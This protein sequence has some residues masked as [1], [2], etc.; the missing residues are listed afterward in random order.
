MSQVDGYLFSV[1]PCQFLKLVGH[2]HVLVACKLPAGI[3]NQGPS[4]S[5][6]GMDLA[7]QGVWKT[8]VQFM[9]K[10]KFAWSSWDF[11][12]PLCATQEVDKSFPILN[13]ALQ[14]I[15]NDV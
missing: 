12:L 4:I 7:S 3:H 11:P 15:S 9:S 1:V 8:K 5:Q 2:S 13:G 6:M 14:L 10:A